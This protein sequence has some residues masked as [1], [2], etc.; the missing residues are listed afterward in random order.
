MF[1]PNGPLK[2]EE[3]P[4]PVCVHVCWAAYCVLLSL[5][6]FVS[7][8]ENAPGFYL[9]LLPGRVFRARAAKSLHCESPLAMF[10]S[11]TGHFLLGFQKHCSLLKSGLQR[12]RVKMKEL[13]IPRAVPAGPA[14]DWGSV[15]LGSSAQ[16]WHAP[17]SVPPLPS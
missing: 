17:A 16:P 4:P 15:D 13:R 11:F 5:S 10:R 14:G 2:V 1:H 12:K 6:S 3:Y 7:C 9:M 8:P